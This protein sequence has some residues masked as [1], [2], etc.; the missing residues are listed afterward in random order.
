MIDHY[1]ISEIGKFG[2]QCMV[3]FRCRCRCRCRSRRC[4]LTCPASARATVALFCFTARSSCRLPW[5]AI[6]LPI[7]RIIFFHPSSTVPGHP[8]RSIL[9]APP[10]RTPP[11]LSA[12][13]K[14]NSW[15]CRP[16]HIIRCDRRPLRG[17]KRASCCCHVGA[18][19]RAVEIYLAVAGWSLR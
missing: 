2:G 6:S 1:L 12:R 14:Y 15:L 19:N 16:N 3:K 11:I 17:A 13:I 9:W 8:H 18:I 7:C 4:R 10:I 5:P